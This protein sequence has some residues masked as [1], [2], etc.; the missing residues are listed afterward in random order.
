M[1]R[2]FVWTRFA[3]VHILLFYCP[4]N[5]GLARLDWLLQLTC[6]CESYPPFLLQCGT[7]DTEV[8]VPSCLEPG[9]VGDSLF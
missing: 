3:I 9:A 1:L 6:V 8:K 5:Q 7:V 2:Y 4:V